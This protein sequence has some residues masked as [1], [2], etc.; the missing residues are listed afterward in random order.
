M[1]ERDK[2]LMTTYPSVWPLPY[3][4]SIRTDYSADH[5]YAIPRSQTQC[6]PVTLGD[7]QQ[8]V[9]NAMH[10]GWLGHQAWVLRG[11]LSADPAGNNILPAAYGANQNVH[12]NYQGN[13]WNFHIA[14]LAKDS[15]QPA[16]IEYLIDPNA[17]YYF[18][19]Q[20]TSNIDDGYYLRF[21]YYGN[22]TTLI[23]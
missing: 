3:G 19:V 20:N 1:H 22:D 10:N 14:N 15:T 8:V 23:T 5:N 13:S 2:Y 6:W 4:V 12:L 21:T 7:Y 16:A 18:N 17:I 11:W 9:I